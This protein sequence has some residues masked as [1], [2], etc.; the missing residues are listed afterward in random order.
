MLTDMALQAKRSA[1]I[2][3]EDC[4]NIKQ[5]I[6]G[7]SARTATTGD[8]IAICPDVPAYN[9]EQVIALDS[10]LMADTYYRQ[11]SERFLNVPGGDLRTLVRNILAK[12][13]SPGLS[14]DIHFTGRS[15][16]F[17]FKNSRL[18]GF[19]LCK[20]INLC[21]LIA[22]RPG[23]QKSRFLHSGSKDCELRSAPV[24]PFATG[25]EEGK[26]VRGEQ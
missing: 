18:H 21:S 4:M 1:A 16:Q 2:A 17:V 7:L 26:N 22:F 6:E 12:L 20:S 25:A 5:S 15:K 11:L 14:G 9:I 8:S 24:V 3:H 19:L 13:I 23:I 10:A